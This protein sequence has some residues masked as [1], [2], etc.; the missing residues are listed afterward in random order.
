MAWTVPMTF[1]D[2]TVLTAAQLNTNLRDNFLETIPAK[3]TNNGGAGAGYFIVQGPHQIAER[4]I[5][6]A[7]VNTSQTTTSSS[8]TN[9]STVGPS[10]SVLT[11]TKAIVIFSAEMGAPAGG[12]ECGVAPEVAGATSIPADDDRALVIAAGPGSRNAA[13]YMAVYTELTPG[14]NIFTLKYMVSQ[15]TGTFLNRHLWVMPF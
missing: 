13:S 5:G 7:E 1:I 11:G 15:Q 14:I 3:A 4:G 12:I 10:V 9:L 8:Y 2:N 6:Y